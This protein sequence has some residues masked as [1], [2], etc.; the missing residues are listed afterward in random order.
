MLPT[1][2]I[3]MWLQLIIAGSLGGV[4]RWLSLR[5]DW[6]AGGGHIIAGAIAGT[7][8]SGFVFA[9]LR[10]L[11]DLSIIQAADAQ[12]LGAHIGGVV[13]INIY[14]IPADFLKMWKPGKASTGQEPSP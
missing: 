9:L 3:P 7:Y 14:T 5:S 11:A 6:R 4:I 2:D 13:G 10:P 8:L 1:L 12:L